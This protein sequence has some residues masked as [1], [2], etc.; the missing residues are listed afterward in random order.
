MDILL[1]SLLIQALNAIQ[2]GLLL[3]L[4]ASGL[5][6]IFGVMGVINIAHG[7]FYMM[8]AYFAF[9]I[10][11]LTGNFFVAVILG[12]ILSVIIGALLEWALFKHLYKRDHLEQV[13]LS[14]G[15]I[16]IFEELR[17][18]F[19]GDEV[20]SIDVPAWLNFSIP[21]GD[22]MSY[23]FYRLFMSG[24]CVLV[25]IG[26]YILINRTRIGSMI[27]AGATNSG[28]AE[29]LGV[30]ISMVNRLVFS[31]GVGLAAFAG[32]INAPAS[33]VAPGMGMEVLIVSFVVVVI[34]GIGSVWGALFAAMVIAF[35][36]TFGSV[37]FPS[38]AGMLT[39]IIM[40]MVLLWRP[41]GIFKR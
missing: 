37:F 15:L 13:L 28:M 7:S 16:L 11:G 40:A 30:N 29:V 35:A 19:V 8:G 36:D 32:M 38:V 17:S 6:L 24:V 22:I 27:R 12:A 25:A 39:Y 20:H 23:P 4:I 33:A 21:L 41:D 5:T 26:M 2:Y 14:Y 1:G 31:L 9:T 18:I 3:F 10:T 34:G